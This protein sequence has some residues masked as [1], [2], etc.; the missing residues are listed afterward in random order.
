MQTKHLLFELGS[1]PVDELMDL[2]KN[3]S[4]DSEYAENALYEFLRRYGDVLKAK[5]RYA[6]GILLKKSSTILNLVYDHAVELAYYQAQTYKPCGAGLTKKETDRHLADWL[7][8]IAEV[9]ADQIGTHEKAFYR[10]HVVTEDMEA[11]SELP[12]WDVTAE[13]ETDPEADYREFL[14]SK[15]LMTLEVVTGQLSKR[16]QDIVY[17]F[18]HPM[19]GKKY[20]DAKQVSAICNKWR[21]SQDNLYQVKHRAFGKIRKLMLEMEESGE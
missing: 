14:R 10:N 18:K 4:N 17:A 9:S 6:A 12:S 3:Q 20:L 13:E 7:A 11:Y 2:I 1:L 15:R 8:V 21:I 16:E 19:A 5:C